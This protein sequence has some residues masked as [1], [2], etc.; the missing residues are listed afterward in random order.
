MVVLRVLD[1]VDWVGMLEVVD[2]G[3]DDVRILVVMP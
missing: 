2:Y 3:C 1:L